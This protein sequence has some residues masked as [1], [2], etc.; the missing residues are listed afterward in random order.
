[1]PVRSSEIQQPPQATHAGHFRHVCTACTIC[2]APDTPSPQ[3]QHSPPPPARSPGGLQS[4]A[5]EGA[6]IRQGK[7]KRHPLNEMFGCRAAPTV[8]HLQN[9]ILDS[10]NSA[11]QRSPHP[12]LALTGHGQSTPS[13]PA[14][15]GMLQ[16]TKP[17]TTHQK[18]RRA[19]SPRR[20]GQSRCRAWSRCCTSPG[21]QQ[22]RP[23]SSGLQGEGGRGGGRGGVEGV[24][25]AC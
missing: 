11:K 17:H 18:R 12:S 24:L 15:W 20:R 1:M 25:E 16:P 7:S 14:P 2:L 4:G 21:S 10:E 5:V 9:A 6:S 19:Q 8:R 22:T 23:S 3:G 13:R